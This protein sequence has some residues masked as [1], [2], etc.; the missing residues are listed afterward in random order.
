MAFTSFNHF[1]AIAGALHKAASQIVK[2]TATDIQTAA[3]STAP[4]GETGFLISSIYRVTS[5]ESTYGQNL[6]EP[7]KG[8]YLMPEIEKPEDDLTA[9]VGVG[10]NYGIYVEMGTRF[11]TAQP[12]FY[13]AVEQ[14]KTTFQNKLDAIEPRMKGLISI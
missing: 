5:E 4:L 2:E 6:A 10:A 7:H 12:Y 9:Y 14:A 1:P 8:S 3:A 13:P 11:M